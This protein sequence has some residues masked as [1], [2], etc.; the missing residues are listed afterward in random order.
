MN[1]LMTMTLALTSMV[2]LMGCGAAPAVTASEDA[3]RFD[4]F[5]AGSEVSVRSES[6]DGLVSESKVVAGADGSFTVARAGAVAV[7]VTVDGVEVLRE[8]LQRHATGELI[9]VAGPDLCGGLPCPE[10]EPLIDL[11]HDPVPPPPAA[12]AATDDLPEAPCGV[13]PRPSIGPQPLP[14]VEFQAAAAEG[15]SR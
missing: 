8:R 3:L 6:R 12:N 11:P 7:A 5:M 9:P 4:G 14:L 15:V 2:T 13:E 1:R 10:P